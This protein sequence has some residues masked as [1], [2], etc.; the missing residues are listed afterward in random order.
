M[1]TLAC[2]Y[3]LNAVFLNGFCCIASF[4]FATYSFL[5]V[6]KHAEQQSEQPKTTPYSTQSFG[7]RRTSRISSSLLPL[8][9]AC[10][11]SQRA[12]NGRDIKMLSMRAPG[13]YSPNFVPRSYTR[14]NSTYLREE[15]ALILDMKG[16]CYEQWTTQKLKVGADNILRDEFKL[17]I[18]QIS[19]IIT[20]LPL[21]NSLKHLPVH[22]QF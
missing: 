4:R 10:M 20:S 8:S 2:T 18:Q 21:E 1:R 11:Y 6:D 12:S 19:N 17:F 16:E 5:F 13:V 9:G 14:L 22:Q 15:I 7:F 3:V